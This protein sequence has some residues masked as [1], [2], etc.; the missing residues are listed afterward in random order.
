MKKT[1]VSTAADL[2]NLLTQKVKKVAPKSDVTIDYPK[3]GD[4]IQP[5]HYAI[6][7]S[8]LGGDSVQLSIDKGDWMWCRHAGGYW[9]FDWHSIPKGNHKLTA[10]MKLPTG[11]F[12][13][14]KIV[15][16]IV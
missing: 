14:S 7:L 9:W 3:T 10:R 12:K 13:Q 2:K 15:S 11:K 8:A 6:R 16:V 5:H 4:R 1:V